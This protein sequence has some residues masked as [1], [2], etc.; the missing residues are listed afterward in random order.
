VLADITTALGEGGIN[1]EDLWVDHTPGGGV[2]RVLVDGGETARRAAE[3][4]EQRSFR[5]TTVAEQ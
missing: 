5:T 3:L 2:L 1:I 4:L